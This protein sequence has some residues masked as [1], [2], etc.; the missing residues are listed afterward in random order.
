MFSRDHRV[1]NDP[2]LGPFPAFLQNYR[3]DEGVC[4]DAKSWPTSSTPAIR[5]CHHET[6]HIQGHRL[7]SLVPVSGW[8]KECSNGRGCTR[9]DPSAS[10]RFLQ[11]RA[12][13]P[14]ARK[15]DGKAARQELAN[16]APQGWR[17]I[18]N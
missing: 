18:E 3:R 1:A 16:R 2:R 5:R 17:A 6:L 12:R 7:R 14:T 11:T 9:Y 15:G 8:S 13:L 4:A 10:E